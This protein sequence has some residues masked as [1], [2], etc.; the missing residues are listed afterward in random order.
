MKLVG[1]I[2]NIW[3][4]DDSIGP[5]VIDTKAL[6]YDDPKESGKR[7]FDEL[8]KEASNAFDNA[9]NLHAA[10]EIFA[11]EHARIKHGK[12]ILTALKIGNPTWPPTPIPQPVF[13]IEMNAD[14]PSLLDL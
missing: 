12:A 9:R 11:V 6:V 10:R 4:L 2:E 7:N 8:W 13:P 3:E 5:S 1:R 14:L